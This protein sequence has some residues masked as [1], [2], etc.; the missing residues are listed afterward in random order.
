MRTMFA[1]IAY[2]QA[3]LQFVPRWRVGY[4][5]DRLEHGDVSIGVVNNALAPRSSMATSAN[6]VVGVGQRSCTPF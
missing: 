3:V 1:F 5:Y 6:K 4:R 2:A